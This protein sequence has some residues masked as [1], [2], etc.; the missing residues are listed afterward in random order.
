MLI[1][2]IGH[3][4]WQGLG[5]EPGNHT[6]LFHRYLNDTLTAFGITPQSYDTRGVT[7]FSG[8]TPAD[9]AGVPAVLFNSTPIPGGNANPD[10]GGTSSL[11]WSTISSPITGEILQTAVSSVTGLKVLEVS[12]VTNALGVSISNDNRTFAVDGSSTSDLT[13]FAAGV[14]TS[15]TVTSKNAAGAITDQL[16]D[17]D[18]NGSFETHNGLLGDDTLTG[19]AIDDKLYGGVGNDT[20]IGNGGNDIL[21]GG[22]GADNLQGGAGNDLYVID[23]TDTLVEAAGAGTDTVNADFSYTLLA[24]FENLNLTGTAAINATGNALD[25]YIVGNAAANVIT[26]LDGNDTLYGLAGND[27]IFGGNGTDNLQ[28]GAGNDV[29]VVDNLDAIIEAAGAGNDTVYVD[30][31]YTL[32]ANLENIVLT[33]AAAINGA[34]N[35][36]ANILVGNDGANTLWGLDGND[37]LS[38][39]L[40]SDILFGGNG[41]DVLYG[42][43]GAGIDNLYGDAGADQF[44]F[45]ALADS[46]VTAGSVADFIQDFEAGIDKV[47]LV[48]LRLT[49][50]DVVIQNSTVSGVNFSTVGYDVNRN[51]G[52]D[53]GEFAISVRLTGTTFLAQSDLLL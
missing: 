17:S 53:N 34:G 38:G 7:P 52:F 9:K 12:T 28:G 23:A 13:S 43:A 44:V 50:A 11:A 16:I 18:A 37:S 35:A 46:L 22:L 31:T 5:T 42:G 6:P 32:A 8:V 51:G 29:Y 30:V 48:A 47:N 4:K 24:N 40:G 26:G 21:D 3:F 41:A 10:I 27:T 2:E 25:N 14:A 45:S 49:A 36:D 19:S 39:G 1:H 15:Q 33:G 20:L